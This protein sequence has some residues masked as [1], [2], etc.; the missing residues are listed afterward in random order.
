MSGTS[1]RFRNGGGRVTDAATSTSVGSA[2]AGRSSV[3]PAKDEGG[4]LGWAKRA[5]NWVGDKWDATTEAVGGFISD[6]SELVGDVAD[7]VTGTDLDYEDGK[8]TVS[9]DLDE[10]ADLM[11]ARLAS[12][13]QLDREASDNRVAITVDRSA[14]TITLR[15]DQIALSGIDLAAVAAGATQASDV[16]IVLTDPDGKLS[17]FGG[18]TDLENYNIQVKVGGV[19]MT[20]LAL[21]DAQGRTQTEVGS[22]ELQ[23]LS[24]AGTREDGGIS[25]QVGLQSAVV[26]GLNGETTADRLDVQ[27]LTGSLS[28]NGEQG[29]LGVESLG[30]KGFVS[31]KGR[32]DASI[33]G[34][35]VD[36]DNR[37]GGLP[38]LDNKKDAIQ[39]RALVRAG[40]LSEVTAGSTEL[41]YLDIAG[42]DLGWDQEGSLVSGTVDSLGMGGLDGATDV[43]RAAVTGAE[44]AFSPGESLSLDAESVQASGVSVQGNKKSPSG[45]GM[46]VSANV[47]KLDIADLALPGG[48]GLQR[49]QSTD[50]G[51][52]KDEKGITATSGYAAVSGVEAGEMSLGSATG[53]GVV[54]ESS[55]DQ[56]RLQAAALDAADFEHG[57]MGIGSASVKGA[58]IAVDSGGV[59]ARASSVAAGGVRYGELGAD[60]VSG[61]G[62]RFQRDR[63]TGEVT[64]SASRV[65]VDGLD[66]GKASAERIDV[67]DLGLSLGGGS[68]RVTADE[69]SAKNLAAGKFSSAG[70]IGTGTDLQFGEKSGIGIGVDQAKL[71]DWSNAGKLGASESTAR[72]AQ[73]QLDK[74]RFG[75]DVA[76][77]DAT[78]FE[79]GGVSIDAVEF[80][81]LGLD[82]KKSTQSVDLQLGSAGFT[83][84]RSEQASVGSG[85]VSGASLQGSGG[86]IRLGIDAL[87][88]RDLELGASSSGV[89][90]KRNGLLDAASLVRSGSA[91]V[92][93][94][95]LSASIGLQS[96][97]IGKGFGSLGVEEG[98]VA[99]ARVVARDGQ[100][101]RDTRVDLNKSLDGPLWTTGRGAYVDE[102]DRLRADVGGGPD[103]NVGKKI[104]KGLG[105]DSKSLAS[106]EQYGAAIADGMG[107]PSK[108]KPGDKPS[109]VDLDGLDASGTIGL[110]SGTLDAGIGSAQLDS[111]KKGSNLVEVEVRGKRVQVD[112]DRLDLAA[113]ALST[114]ELDVTVADADLEAAG[115][116]LDGNNGDLDATLASIRLRKIELSKGK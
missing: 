92:D 45:G 22:A 95:D 99:D 73:I 102:K 13:F 23:G 71:T 86:D 88:A 98:T 68:G 34:L 17:V 18:L 74:G 89:G 65:G 29:S 47:G 3:A 57:K 69:V 51:F 28:A 108:K 115:V 111:S 87:D 82:A 40:K 72:D 96:G 9:T 43:D 60:G 75:L 30:A 33:Q 59:D 116:L 62:V 78:G 14:G 16:E 97:E 114:G 79:A 35:D 90:S 112:I 38:F 36:I 50:V 104:N 113:I 83:G 10:V 25:A 6:T 7:V 1:R 15:S 85:E 27:G 58:D 63:G 54:F 8:L 91:L 24:F 55:G 94:V 67:Q 66:A 21:K 61:S 101:T 37:G 26:K 103:I 52:A 93:D 109:I 106:I 48:V 19:D 11:P 110:K 84:L 12:Q 44:F 46:D 70:I 64:G 5:G 107:G 81:E 77:G 41:G 100:F 49:V 76:S 56:L 4:F 20:D 32:G 53:G 80:A 39:A 31:E 105:I 42:A 2:E